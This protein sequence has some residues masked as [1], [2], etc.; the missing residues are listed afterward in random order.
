MADV[1]QTRILAHLFIHFQ[2]RNRIEEEIWR[3]LKRPAMDHAQILR[4]RVLLP[5]SPHISLNN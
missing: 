4:P 3:H 2:D 1:T 5:L